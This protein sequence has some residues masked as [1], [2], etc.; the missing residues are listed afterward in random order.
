MIG[1]PH[2]ERVDGS[3]WSSENRKHVL[4]AQGR[5]EESAEE[6]ESVPAPIL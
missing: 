5:S 4:S 1:E 6:H 2:C 3:T